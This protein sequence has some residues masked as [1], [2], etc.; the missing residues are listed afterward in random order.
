MGRCFKTLILET[1]KCWLLYTLIVSNEYTMVIHVGFAA[2]TNGD[3]F[4]Y[5]GNIEFVERSLTQGGIP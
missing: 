4:H 1:V 3:G 2:L 5:F